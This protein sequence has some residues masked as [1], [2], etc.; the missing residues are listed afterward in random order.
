VHEEWSDNWLGFECFADDAIVI[1]QPGKHTAVSSSRKIGGF[2]SPAPGDS[3]PLFEHAAPGTGLTERRALSFIN[4][5]L[6]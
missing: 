1:D 2:S 4:A 5:P 6:E 3:W